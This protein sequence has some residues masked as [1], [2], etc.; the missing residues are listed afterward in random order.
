MTQSF[1]GNVTHQEQKLLEI[2]LLC[3]GFTACPLGGATCSTCFEEFVVNRHIRHGNKKKT[4]TLSKNLATF[5]LNR[6]ISKIQEFC[7][8]TEYRKISQKLRYAIRDTR[9][10]LV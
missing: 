5:F 3:H 1:Q 6:E 10:A 8:E 9:T 2:F 4:R 7:F